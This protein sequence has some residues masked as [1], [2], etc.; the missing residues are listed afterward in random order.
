MSADN[1]NNAIR[2]REAVAMNELVEE[3][4]RDMK[5]VS[6]VNRQRLAVAWN[7]VSGAE[8]YTVDI[9][10]KDRILYCTIGSSMVRNQLYFQKDV[11]MNQINAFLEE[12]EIFVKDGEK[13]YVREI[14]L[15]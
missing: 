2:R 7:T 6:G 11:L 1:R 15:R 5:L 4:I 9:Y 3:F 10:F 8:R 13:P 14:V 12:D